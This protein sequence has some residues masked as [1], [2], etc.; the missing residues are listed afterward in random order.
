M[1]YSCDCGMSVNVSC[2]ECD[3]EMKHAIIEKD[4]KKIQ[5]TECNEGCGKIKSPM[6]C[7]R[8]MKPEIQN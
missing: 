1:K 2:G 6:C 8:D 4:G 3:D 7:G 5:V